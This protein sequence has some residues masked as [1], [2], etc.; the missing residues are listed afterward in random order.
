MTD[1]P[2]N[3]LCVCV[4]VYVHTRVLST[5]LPWNLRSVCA[6]GEDL[7]SPTWKE[8]GDTYKEAAAGMARQAHSLF[9]QIFRHP[10]RKNILQQRSC[11][12]PTLLPLSLC[13]PGTDNPSLAPPWVCSQASLDGAKLGSQASPSFGSPRLAFPQQFNHSSSPKRN[14]P[15]HL[16]LEPNC[17]Q[18]PGFA[19]TC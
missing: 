9:L 7:R 15:R 13:V 8:R 2:R 11:L 16:C 17:I 10:C 4:C 18:E 1:N 19:H 12:I 6:E 5:T 14:V 3:P